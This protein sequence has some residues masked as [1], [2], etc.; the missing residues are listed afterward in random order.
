MTEL[1]TRFTCDVCFKAYRWRPELAGRRVK[2]A[3]GRVMTAPSAPPAEEEELYDLVPDDEPKRAMKVTAIEHPVVPIKEAPFVPG[4]AVAYA[5]NEAAIGESRVEQY[6]PDRVKDL[7]IPLALIGAGTIIDVAMYLFA[8]RASSRASIVGPGAA[9]AGA[10]AAVGISMLVQ[11]GIMLATV[12][13]VAKVRGISFGPVP[14]A[15]IKLCGISIGPGAIGSVVG[16]V[17]GFLPLIGG[18][19]GWI[20]GF[21]LYFACIGALFELDESDTW[22]VVVSVFFAKLLFVFV[23]LGLILHAL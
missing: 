2:C 19:L 15:I 9:L 21:I 12:F 22:A 4:A 14:T 1:S 10:L 8:G 11:A 20:A 7:Y 23:V 5:R 3:C 13:C 16:L 6:F 17:L 18:L